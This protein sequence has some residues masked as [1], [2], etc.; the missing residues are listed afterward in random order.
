VRA[1]TVETLRA[2][3][4]AAFLTE[5]KVLDVIEAMEEAGELGNVKDGEGDRRGI[6]LR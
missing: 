3:D 4:L 2:S 5:P 1:A 6:V